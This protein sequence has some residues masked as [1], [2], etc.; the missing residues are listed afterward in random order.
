MCSASPRRHR[1]KDPPR[2][3]TK[4]GD[5]Q[6]GVPPSDASHSPGTPASSRPGLQRKRPPAGVAPSDASDCSLVARSNSLSPSLLRSPIGACLCSLT[7]SFR[8]FPLGGGHRTRN[9]QRFRT[10]SA[11]SESNHS[12]P[13]GVAYLVESRMSRPHRRRAGTPL[14][15]PAS[16]QHHRPNRTAGSGQQGS[17]GGFGTGAA[18]GRVK[19][20]GC[21]AFSH[22]STPP[23]SA[24]IAHALPH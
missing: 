10:Y 18:R 3:K 9:S 7:M 8:I 12:T 2:S 5:R 14:G 1:R 6:T 22:L 21:S 15:T 19:R 16:R 20:S 23:P 11:A 13:E 4:T 24:T 17:T